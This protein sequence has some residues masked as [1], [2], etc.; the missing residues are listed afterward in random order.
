MSKTYNPTITGKGGTGPITSGRAMLYVCLPPLLHE[1][2]VCERVILER[3][4][5]SGN[6]KPLN[7]TQS[8]L[9]DSNIR[10]HLNL[11]PKAP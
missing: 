9:G 10:K 7:A 2:K 8:P 1:W 6:L 11:E 4:E 5:G 3:G